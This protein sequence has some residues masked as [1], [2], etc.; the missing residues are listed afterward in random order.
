MELDE[1][2]VLDVMSPVGW[3]GV[4]GPENEEED[5]LLNIGPEFVVFGPELGPD[6]VLG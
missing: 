3:I 1:S 4:I 5:D 2:N 6:L